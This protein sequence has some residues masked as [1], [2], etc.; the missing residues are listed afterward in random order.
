MQPITAS[1]DRANRGT[2]T[3]R[4]RWIWVL[5]GTLTVAAI[6]A[7]SAAAVATAGNPTGQP[8][9][10][11]PGRTVLVTQPVSALSV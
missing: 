2:R 4:G 3:V 1:D 11:L 9:V 10:T 7:L 5:S 6:G 8:E